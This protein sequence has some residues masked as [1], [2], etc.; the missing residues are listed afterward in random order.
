TTFTQVRRDVYGELHPDARK[1]ENIELVKLAS[2]PFSQPRYEAVANVLSVE[3]SDLDASSIEQA[4]ERY[5]ARNLNASTLE[6]YG[7]LLEKLVRGELL[8][9]SG[10]DQLFADMKIDSY[11]NYRL[12]A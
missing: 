3:Q 9:E 5:Y 6:A 12:E 4:Y 8:S 1:L 2:S 11:D 10:M 7:V